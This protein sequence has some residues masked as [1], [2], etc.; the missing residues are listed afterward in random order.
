MS[1]GL[2]QPAAIIGHSNTE[3]QTRPV[4]RTVR[5]SPG[6]TLPRLAA[7]VSTFPK[8]D[9]LCVSPPFHLQALFRCLLSLRRLT[10]TP[11]LG[12]FDRTTKGAFVGCGAL[13][14]RLLDLRPRIHVMGHIHESHGA[15]IHAWQCN[16]AGK[17]VQPTASDGDTA[18]D[19]AEQSLLAFST[20][21]GESEDMDVDGD[22]SALPTSESTVFV[23]AAN[24]PRAN[25]RDGTRVRQETV[26]GGPG[27]QPVVVDLKDYPNERDL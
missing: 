20:E 3:N 26:F 5:Y 4:G 2:L 8:T 10:H 25:R 18:E 9:I 7:L 13:L 15:H 24:A 22:D 12:I 1:S 19:E 14:D 21:Q 11:P 6:L 17:F 16:Q 23:N 27:Y